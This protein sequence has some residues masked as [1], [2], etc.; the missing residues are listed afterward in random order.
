MIYPQQPVAAAPMTIIP[1]A[2]ATTTGSGLSCWYSFSTAITVG[3]AAV[4]STLAE[5]PDA[6]RVPVTGSSGSCSFPPSAAVM[7][8]PDVAAAATSSF[9][10]KGC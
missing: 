7:A 1:A 8:A 9:V 10:R 2:A 5:A 4:V 6:V 3:A